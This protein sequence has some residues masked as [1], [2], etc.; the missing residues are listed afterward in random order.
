MSSA[1]NFLR[2][3]HPG[4]S[5][6][7]TCIEP[8]TK[9]I[10]ACTFDDIEPM[11]SWIE[12]WNG[13]RNIYFSVNPTTRP[14]SKKPA[15]KDIKEVAYLHVDVDPRVGED[16]GEEQARIKAL[17]TTDLPDGVPPPTFVVLSGGGYQAFWK[18]KEPIAVDGDI[19]KAED[20]KLY[21]VALER[22]FGADSCH[23]V[24]RIM[25]V[26]GTW[27]LPDAKKLAKGRV[28][29]EARVELSE[30]GREYDLTC[31]EK[32]EPG[33]R[34]TVRQSP[35]AISAATDATLASVDDLDQWGVP[36]RVKAIIVDGSDPDSPK[37]GDNSR[38]VWLWDVCC[39]LARCNVPDEIIF[40]VITDNDFAISESVLEKGR[41]WREYAL[42]TVDRAIDEAVD[43]V[44]RELNDRYMVI[45]NLGGRCRVVHEVDDLGRRKLVKQSFE[46]F[47]N[48]YL[49]KRIQTGTDRQGNPTYTA[50]GKWWLEHSR[51]REFERIEFKPEQDVNNDVFNLWRGFA[52]ESAPGECELLLAHVRDNICGGDADLYRY[53]V[54]WMARA[55][56][57]PGVPAETAIVLRGG[58]GVGKSFF[59]KTFGHLFGQHYLHISNAGHVVGN[60]NAHLRDCVLLFGDEAFYAG[61]KRHESQ[62]KTLVTEYTLM[63]EGKGIDAESSASCL[64]IIL[65]SNKKWV[66]PADADDRRFLV[67]D[68]GDG[69]KQN[70]TYFKAIQDQLDDGGYEALLHYLQAFDISTFDHRTIPDTAAKRDQ[71][72]RSLDVYQQIIFEMLEEGDSRSACED[73]DGHWVRGPDL[74]RH[75]RGRSAET[76]IGRILLAISERKGKRM[77]NEHG[78]MKQRWCYLL[79]PL[80]TAREAFEEHVGFEIDWSDCQGWDELHQEQDNMPF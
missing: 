29:V 36:D 6:T 57:Q 37:V 3:F 8:D 45:K 23:N 68:V 56:Q 25:R 71:K 69:Q 53:V 46:D 1:E 62:L 9:V 78:E 61:D 30:P 16:L 80:S 49:N 77:V 50:T 2:E 15:R 76:S 55:V 75:M 47:R 60:F 74:V 19:D 64:H 38:S 20:A 79:K 41:R 67:L 65:A 70:L 12:R 40:A 17:V 42:R 24:D 7:L 35:I 31:F 73:G 21:N 63:I 11:R 58:Q 39:N 54:S 33:A 27:N 43:P 18:L 28:K 5:W 32:A 51:R 26:P 44:L 13:T 22:A 52:V 72:L 48:A 59:A 14:L 34:V 4:G 66:V 10:D